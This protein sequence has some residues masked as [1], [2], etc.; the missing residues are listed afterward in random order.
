VDKHIDTSIPSQSTGASVSLSRENSSESLAY[1]GK[2]DE[3]PV[4]LH[5]EPSPLS[6]VLRNINFDLECPVTAGLIN[7]ITLGA[8]PFIP[9]F[10]KDFTYKLKPVSFSF[11]PDR[12]CPKR[13][14]L[15]CCQVGFSLANALRSSGS[16]TERRTLARAD[17][18]RAL[19]VLG[20]KIGG[21]GV[22]PSCQLSQRADLCPLRAAPS[23]SSC[24][25][26]SC[27]LV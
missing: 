12:S 25:A 26:G 8:A 18:H 3:L 20:C 11:A 16:N 9:D 5:F 19:D 4:K 6:L 14:W 2:L 7:G 10:L 24:C 13:L 27:V 1:T 21:G 17:G 15:Y 23:Q 22:G